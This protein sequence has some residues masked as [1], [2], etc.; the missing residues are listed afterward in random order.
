MAV[1]EEY[2]AKLLDLVF[3]A[4]HSLLGPRGQSLVA[5][6]FD[7]SEVPR[8]PNSPS[9][10]QLLD[11]IPRPERRPHV[12]QKALKFR[13]ALARQNQLR[14]N[15]FRAQAVTNAIQTSFALRFI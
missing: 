9:N 8:Q 3:L 15:Q 7:A 10:H 12:L 4:A 1:S 13:L 2:H 6:G 14:R 11:L 5:R